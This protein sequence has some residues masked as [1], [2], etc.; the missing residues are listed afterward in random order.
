V[1]KKSIVIAWHGLPYYAARLLSR[2]PNTDGIHLQ[3]IGTECPVPRHEVEDILGREVT[4]VAHDRPLRWADINL[5][6]PDIFFH[7]GWVHPGFKSLAHAVKRSAG[8]VILTLDNNQKHNLRQ[9]LGG[10]AFRAFIRRRIDGAWV[11]GESCYRL[12]RSFGLPADKI[13][14]GLYGADP[15]IFR[16]GPPLNERPKQFIFVGQFVQRK[17]P[18]L[19]LRAFQRFRLQNPEWRMAFVGSGPL[20]SSLKGPAV[21]VLPFLPSLQVAEKMRESRFLILPSHEE[22]WGVVV[23]EA[24]LSGCGLILSDVIG[25]G[26]DLLSAANGYSFRAGDESA[27][28]QSLCRAANIDADEMGKISAESI[29][30]AANFG[31]SH[32]TR[33]FARIVEDFG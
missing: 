17:A 6:I 15:S 18:D 19:L 10:L 29:R 31:P 22:H 24:T 11:S 16:P 20:E 4:W 23:H 1:R 13:Y 5:E 28:Y 33:S 8:A 26:A 30:L 9:F 12:M 21:E 25:A 32:F 27:L 3:F 7:T 2:L 14:T